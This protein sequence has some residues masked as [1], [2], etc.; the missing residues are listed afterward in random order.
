MFASKEHKRKFMAL[1]HSNGVY[2]MEYIDEA[3]DTSDIQDYELKTGSMYIDDS[4][5]PYYAFL[6]CATKSGLTIDKAKSIMGIKSRPKI[7]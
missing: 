6:M 2:G 1:Y 7:Q 3:N 4:L 5:R